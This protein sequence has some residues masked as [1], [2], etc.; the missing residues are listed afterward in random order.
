MFTV[1]TSGKAAPG[2]STASWALALS[3]PRPVI[4]A[5]CDPAGGDL[6]AG[7]LAGRVTQDRGLLSWSSQARRGTPALAAAGMLA[8][9]AVEVP[10]HPNVW[11][12]PGFTNMTQGY[13]F[14]DDVWQ[15]L[16]LALERVLGSARSGRAGR[17]RPAGRGSGPAGR[18]CGAAD[19]VLVAVRPSVRSVHAAQDITQRLWHELGDVS[20]VSALVVGDGP[21]P[22]REVASALQLRLAGSCRW[23][24]GRPRRCRTGRARRCERC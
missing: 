8:A 10:E 17:H 1:I 5:D 14:T 9:H 19:Q 11:L 24:G 22:A 7:L 20:K 21:Y 2:V 23:T 16:A 13:S 3:W 4:L 12:L 18:C 15:R 6:A